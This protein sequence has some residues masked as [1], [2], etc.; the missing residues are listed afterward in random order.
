MFQISLRLFSFKQLNCRFFSERS[1]FWLVKKVFLWIIFSI[2][3]LEF[4]PNIV[5]WFITLFTLF[6]LPTF[7]LAN[8]L[9]TSLV[10][11]KRVLTCQRIKELPTLKVTLDWGNVFPKLDPSKD[12]KFFIFSFSSGVLPR[13][14]S[15][16]FERYRPQNPIIYLSPHWK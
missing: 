5:P 12:E 15:F 7:C 9:I 6:N 10:W 11:K 8:Q 16:S 14:F 13:F 4:L 1:F 3:S 2:F